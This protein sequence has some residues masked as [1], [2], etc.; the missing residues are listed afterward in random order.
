M[1][2]TGSGV[3]A[4]E[5]AAR[6]QVPTSHVVVGGGQPRLS[7]LS[8][9]RAGARDR[10]V[11]PSTKGTTRR[12]LPAP[13]GG[14]GHGVAR[15]VWARTMPTRTTTPPATCQPV[16]TCPSQSQATIEAN[17]GSTVADQ[18]ADVGERCRQRGD[19]QPERHDRP[20][21]DDPGHE[22]PQRHRQPPRDSGTPSRQHPG[23]ELPP[24]RRDRPRRARPPR[25]SSRSARSGRDR[26]C[27][28]RPS[29]SRRPGR[30]P[31]ASPAATPT[32]SRSRRP[33]RPAATSTSP[34]S[35]SSSATHSRLRT[36]SR[37]T[38]QT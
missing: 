12:A 36:C 23:V 17:T 8:A 38:S 24:R 34:D 22:Q 33:A 29:G 10:R 6:E 27:R 19:R 28:A 20:E 16:S 15:A 21:D 1:A 4:R 35:E 2:A 26:P 5:A 37:R 13:R 31:P 32:G 25:S 30:G 7:N 18:P 14:G 11:R 3:D 9:S